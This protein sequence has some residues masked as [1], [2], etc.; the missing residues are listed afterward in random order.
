MATTDA[1]PTSKEFG[2]IADVLESTGASTTPLADSL[3]DASKA[4]EH[5]ELDGTS[6][7]PQLA[8]AALASEEKPRWYLLRFGPWWEF[9]SA[10]DRKMPKA[11]VLPSVAATLVPIT[12]LFV[13][14]ALEGN[15]IQAGPGNDGRRI[16]KA[17]GYV[18][19]N[20]VATA[21]AF[22]N[23]F[24]ITMRQIDAFRR[25][26]S[27]RIAALI[28]IAI[29]L[30]LG[31]ICLVIAVL[32]QYNVVN[33]ANVWITPEYPCIYVGGCLAL[34]Q[35]ALLIADYLTTPS[36]NDRGHGF[37]SA[38]MQA[39]IGLSNLVALWTGFGGLIFS[40]VEDSRIWHSFN[41]CFTSWVLLITTGSTALNFETTNSKLFVMFW[42]PIGVL[43]MFVFFWCFG[44]G[45]VHRFDEKPQR[46]I[47]RTEEQLRRAYRAM[48]HP[49]QDTAQVASSIEALQQ[50]LLYLHDRRL[51]YFVLLFAAG[52]A[53]KACCWVLGSIAFTL[54]EAGWSYWDSMVFLF[55]NVL[56]VGRQGMVPESAVGTAI[57]LAFTFVDLL[58][59]AAVYALLLHILLNLA[60][61]PRY[62]RYAKSVAVAV[63]A[64]L[65]LRKRRHR[66]DSVSDNGVAT[67]IP[68]TREGDGPDSPD[69]D[70]NELALRCS[71][72]DQ[73]ESAISIVC[74]LRALLVRN[75][76]SDADLQE[77]DRLLASVERR[78]DAIHLSNAKG[79]IVLS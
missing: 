10:D 58:A 38:A 7:P 74:Q 20:A 33:H 35:A 17:G 73:L 41:S 42:L 2:H 67:E 9:C 48:R 27:L 63:I 28:Q 77:Y 75:E 1:S 12:I 53:L 22:L 39:A 46:R 31:A 34:L 71:A 65:A 32:Y 23:A 69:D 15:W 30:A 11:R 4:E 60:P 68:S 24:T 62:R 52:A 13:L 43:L 70:N 21:L 25:F 49:E 50:R 61:W 59:T 56:A 45:V 57:Y 40:N 47:R 5:Y 51:R 19:G 37:G 6:T 55:L 3:T 29:N 16:H 64:K 36:F 66:D 44:F 78:A 14:T 26:F 72:A 79:A 18:A 76:A 8:H 54:T